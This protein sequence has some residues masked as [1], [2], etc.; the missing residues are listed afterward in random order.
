MRQVE[1][2]HTLESHNAKLPPVLST[3][4]MIAWMEIACFV[5]TEPFCEAD[6]IT[7][8]T[9]IHVSHRAPTGIGNQIV[10]EAVL[11]KVDGRFFIF[12]VS[13]RDQHQVIG[14]GHVHR[15]F[16]SLGKFMG[17]QGLRK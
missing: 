7:V 8:G 14:E 4:N 17:K 3:P 16:V 2:Q 12:R 5:A 6:E 9:A 10:A 1:F 11:E 15:A 13:A